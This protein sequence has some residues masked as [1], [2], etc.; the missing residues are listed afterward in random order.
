VAATASSARRY[1]PW[2]QR[3]CVVPGGDFFA[4]LRAGTA[5]V[6]TGVLDRFTTGGVRLTDGTELPADVIVTATGLQLVLLGE[7]EV[8][9]DGRRF[10]PAASH[11]Y[12]GMMFD[13][14]PNLAWC[15][16]YINASWTLRADLTSRYLC[17]LLNYAGRHRIDVVTPQLPPDVH[18]TDEP[19]MALTS[20]YVS[21]AAG[22]LPRQGTRRPWRTVDNYLTDY[23]AM[24]LGRIDDGNVRFERLPAGV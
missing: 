3:L 13:G 14:V 20:G 19:L 8:D 6:A 9:V 1:D 7:I 16:G 11:V 17:R 2:D 12:K 4:A 15:I 10:D 23:P 21:R 24:T 22:A 5:S 18:G